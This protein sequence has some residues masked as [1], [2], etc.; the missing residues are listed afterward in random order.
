MVGFS[1]RLL[2]ESPSSSWLLCRE[3]PRVPCPLFRHSLKVRHV[4]FYGQKKKTL[5][6]VNRPLGVINGMLLGYSIGNFHDVFSKAWCPLYEPHC[7]RFAMD[8]KNGEFLEVHWYDD[9]ICLLCW[10][11]ATHS[12]YQ[13]FVLYETPPP[14]KLPFKLKGSVELVLQMETQRRHFL[15]LKNDDEAYVGNDYRRHPEEKEDDDETPFAF[16]GMKEALRR[17]VG[18][19]QG[20]GRH[21]SYNPLNLSVTD[22]FTFP[23]KQVSYI[24]QDHGSNGEDEEESQLFSSFGVAEPPLFSM[25]LPVVTTATSALESAVMQEILRQESFHLR[26]SDPTISDELFQSIVTREKRW[27]RRLWRNFRRQVYERRCRIE[28]AVVPLV[29]HSAAM[30][31]GFSLSS[32]TLQQHQIQFASNVED[33][34]LRG[35]LSSLLKLS[36]GLWIVSSSGEN[37]FMVDP[38]TRSSSN[39]KKQTT[40]NSNSETKRKTTTSTSGATNV[41]L[42][43]MSTRDVEQ[44]QESWIASTSC[45]SQEPSFSSSVHSPGTTSHEAA[46]IEKVQ[47]LETQNA[48]LMQRIQQLEKERE[49]YLSLSTTVQ[50][51]NRASGEGEQ[52]DK[53]TQESNYYDEL[54]Q[55]LRNIDSSVY[56]QWEVVENNQSDFLL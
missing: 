32:P 50:Q 53:L 16:P 46:W 23:Y 36:T 48:M 14:S 7:R 19:F 29:A 47:R 21:A 22:D 17:V 42:D 24:L 1:L 55:I 52:E 38:H 15:S 30:H 13:Y 4:M 49:R 6:I 12:V 27:S 20:T 51:E 10:R 31:L 8:L 40:K 26:A 5:D 9:N 37:L 3:E 44:R 41:A 54:N 35:L 43:E 34:E 45:N 28:E 18:V 33:E 39:N 25:S 11:Q 56:S 2:Q